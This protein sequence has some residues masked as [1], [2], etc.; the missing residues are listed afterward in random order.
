VLSS[1]DTTAVERKG[2]QF[3][4][5]ISVD[6]YEKQKKE[7]T[8]IALKKLSAVRSS[9]AEQKNLVLQYNA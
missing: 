4:S 8:E 7:Y 9:N 3:V 5:K 1:G 2:V 6:A